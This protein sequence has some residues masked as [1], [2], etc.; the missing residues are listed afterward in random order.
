[1]DHIQIN[2]ELIEQLIE[3]SKEAGR[4]IMKIYSSDF[5]Y[6]I[7]KDLSPLTKADQVSHEVICKQLKLI[8]PDLPILSEEDSDISFEA[9]TE[10]KKYWL[11]DPLD[12]TKEFIKRNGE[13]TVNI[14]LIDNNV[15]VLGVIHIPVTN[16]TY[17]GSKENGSF[18]AEGDNKPEKINVS[19]N[20]TGPI[21]IA[22]S[23]SHPSK[24]LDHILEEIKDY[25]I[26][27]KGS[28]IKFCLIAC[29]QADIY[30]RFGLTSEWDTAAGDA[31]VKYAG[32][33]VA[34]LSGE[35][36]AYNLKDNLLNPNFIVSN[37][38]RNIQKLQNIIERKSLNKNCLD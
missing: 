17:W 6:Q 1:M 25:E 3:I 9:R 36:I 15:P 34:I 5:D 38:K 20:S 12:G 10:W 37:S 26:I 23:R 21:R 29:G 30:P 18:Y 33:Y 13:F 2:S 14:A 4:E 11:V 27:I 28:S 24:L 31:I 19:G 35:S 7:K 16:E 22:I 8:T 32:G